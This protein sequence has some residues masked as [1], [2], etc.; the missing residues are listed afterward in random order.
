[1][2]FRSV[3]TSVLLHSNR[4]VLVVSLTAFLWRCRITCHFPVAK[5]LVLIA[6][7]CRCILKACTVRLSYFITR[8]SRNAEAHSCN[9]CCSGNSINSTYSECVCVCSLSYSACNPLASYCH[10]WPLLLCNIFFHLSNG[11]IFG[12]K[13]AIE[14]KMNILIFSTHLKHFS[15]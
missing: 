13:K 11:T 6:H 8:L 10:L 1:M 7:F 14:H 15:F 4:C 2:V 5:L 9:R 3:N 12:G